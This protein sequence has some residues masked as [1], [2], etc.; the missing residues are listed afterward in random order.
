MVRSGLG[1]E[2][3]TARVHLASRRRGGSAAVP[4]ACAAAGEPVIGFLNG[5]SAWE[6]APQTVAFRQGLSETGYVARCGA[7]PGVRS[8]VFQ[9][10]FGGWCAAQRPRPSAS[11]S[12][13]AVVVAVTAFALENGAPAFMRSPVRTFSLEERAWFPSFH[14]CAPF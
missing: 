13:A 4:G 12:P 2:H 11:R 14:F 8:S 10:F 9:V 1:D 6:Y 3:E 5:A 7:V